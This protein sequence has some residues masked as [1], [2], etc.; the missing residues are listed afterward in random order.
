VHAHGGKVKAVNRHPCGAKI[1]ATIPVETF[2]GELLEE[3]A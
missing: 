3:L 1:I 2:K